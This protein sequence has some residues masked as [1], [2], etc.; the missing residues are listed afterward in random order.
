MYFHYPISFGAF[1]PRWRTKK[2]LMRNV[3]Q[4][5]G[6]RGT[7][8]A[9]SSPSLAARNFKSQRTLNPSLVNEVRCTRS[10]SQVKGV[11]SYNMFIHSWF[12]LIAIWLI[13]CGML[14]LCL[15]GLGSWY[16]LVLKTLPVSTSLVHDWDEG[17]LVLEGGMVP[18]YVN[19]FP[20]MFYRSF[21]YVFMAL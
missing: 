5:V 4:A 17:Q 1:L 16:L 13:L 8:V 21:M 12:M 18:D 6:L 3:F 20:P 15:L 7:W 14:C 10:K 11:Y 9:P 2:R 19:L